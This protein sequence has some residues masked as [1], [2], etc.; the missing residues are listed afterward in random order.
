MRYYLVKGKEN[1]KECKYNRSKEQSLSQGLRWNSQWRI[2]PMPWA[3]LNSRK[4]LWCCAEF[5]TPP[6]ETCT[7]GHLRKLIQGNCLARSS[8]PPNKPRA[9]LEEAPGYWVLAT[10]N[11]KK[12]VLWQQPTLQDRD[13]A[14]Q[15]CCRM[16]TLQDGGAAGWGRCR[17]GVLKDESNG[18]A[19]YAIWPRCWNHLHA[20]ACQL[21]LWEPG[22]K[23]PSCNVSTMSST[24]KV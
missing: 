10:M 14:G 24:L 11:C 9:V 7:L 16:G 5:A 12:Q 22:R 2:S 1:S 23:T 20:E 21:S 15:G 6:P 19:M 18:E 13:T 4:I 17:M 8:L 3:L